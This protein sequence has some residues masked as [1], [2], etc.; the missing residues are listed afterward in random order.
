[1]NT[2]IEIKEVP[3]VSYVCKCHNILRIVE[4]ILVVY[5]LARAK[6]W[7]Q[8]FI[9]GTSCRQTAIQYLIVGIKEDGVLKNTLLSPPITL[10]G[11][12]SEQ[13]FGVISAMIER[14]VSR[15]KRWKEVMERNYPLYQYDIRNDVGI[16]IV[17]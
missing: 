9:D 7:Q 12:S 5:R 11:E 13:N 8:L 4:E 3:S 16:Y 17:N 1:M 2:N 6:H 15:L 14:G 10:V